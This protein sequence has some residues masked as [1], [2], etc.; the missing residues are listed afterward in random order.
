VPA[1]SGHV[2]AG[3]AT[4]A[5]EAAAVEFSTEAWKMIAVRRFEIA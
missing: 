2:V 3:D 1:G 4:E 5:I